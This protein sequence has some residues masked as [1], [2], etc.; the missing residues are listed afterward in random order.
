MGRNFFYACCVE[1]GFRCR[2]DDVLE[3]EGEGPVK[4]GEI[5]QQSEVKSKINSTNE[6]RKKG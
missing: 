2:L 5:E 3:G 6:S 4:K 1:F